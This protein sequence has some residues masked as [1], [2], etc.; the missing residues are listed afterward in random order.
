MIKFRATT[1]DKNL[2]IAAFGKQSE[3]CITLERTHKDVFKVKIYAEGDSVAIFEMDPVTLTIGN[4]LSLDGVYIDI[5]MD[6]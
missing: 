1:H 6:D 5:T 2:A 4:S 3:C